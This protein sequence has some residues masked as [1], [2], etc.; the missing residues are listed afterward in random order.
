[1]FIRLIVQ[2]AY[3]FLVIVDTLLSIRFVLKFINIPAKAPIVV[4]LYDLT[5]KILYPFVGILSQNH[6]NFLGFTIELT[7]LLVLFL[8]TICSYALYEIIR[9]YN[10]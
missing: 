3:T 2:I 1:M 5:D 4:W 7:T 6:L 8:I 9:A 10:Q